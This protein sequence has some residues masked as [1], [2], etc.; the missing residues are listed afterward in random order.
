MKKARKSQAKP[1]DE[2]LK[3]A[4][5]EESPSVHLADKSETAQPTPSIALEAKSSVSESKSKISDDKKLT[6]AK[7]TVPSPKKKNARDFRSE[8]ILR[9]LKTLARAPNAFKV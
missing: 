8:A 7:N 9:V 2:K 1:P 6:E 5:L 3:K 4:K